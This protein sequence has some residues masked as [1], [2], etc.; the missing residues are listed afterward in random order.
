MVKYI[1][2]RKPWES[3]FSR[4]LVVDD[5]GLELRILF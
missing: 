1:E 2:K 3:L 4:L 5:Q